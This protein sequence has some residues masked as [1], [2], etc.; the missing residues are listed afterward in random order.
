MSGAVTGSRMV[1]SAGDHFLVVGGGPAG[2]IAA[3]ELARRCVGVRLIERSAYASSGSRAKGLQPRTLELLESLGVLNEV[4]T[5]GGRFPRWRSYRA[6]RRGRSPSMNCSASVSR[7][8]IRPFPISSIADV[9][10]TDL[11]RSYWLNWSDPSDAA[12]RVFICPLPA[13]DTFQFVAPL[14]PGE[15]APA[16][17]LATV[18]RLFDEVV[19]RRHRALQ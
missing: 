2:L 5:F 13:T 15:D 7:W 18:Q 9:R 11:D 4:F 19:R 14:L 10:T 8:P 1:I 6:G 3:L 17:T 16:L 12:A